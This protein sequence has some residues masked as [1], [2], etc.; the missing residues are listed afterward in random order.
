METQRI[1][2]GMGDD[3]GALSVPRGRELTREAERPLVASYSAPLLSFH[4]R[5]MSTLRA[6]RRH[7]ASS[8]HHR[9]RNA[10]PAI[11]R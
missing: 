4:P 10:Q 8:E 3:G 2:P 6:G 9:D 11:R 1:G 7:G 5:A